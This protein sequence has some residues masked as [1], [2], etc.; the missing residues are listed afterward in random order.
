MGGKLF[1]GRRRAF[2]IR[3]RAESVPRLQVHGRWMFPMW[4]W[5]LLNSVHQGQKEKI[6]FAWNLIS[7]SNI[8]S[9]NTVGCFNQ[10]WKGKTFIFFSFFSK[11]K[12]IKVWAKRKRQNRSARCILQLQSPFTSSAFCVFLFTSRKLILLICSFYSWHAKKCF[13]FCF[14]WQSWKSKRDKERKLRKTET[15]DWKSKI[16]SYPDKLESSIR[17]SLL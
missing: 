14:G 15:K 11:S 4:I 9:W 13:T 1:S 10:W 3:M 12:M 7:S 16:S 2:S 5:N 17:L 8:Y 6:T